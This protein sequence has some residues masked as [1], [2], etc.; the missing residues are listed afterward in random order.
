MCTRSEDRAYGV[1]LGLQERA[2]IRIEKQCHQLEVAIIWGFAIGLFE[3]CAHV[4]RRSIGC[5]S[6]CDWLV[7]STA[8]V[9]ASNGF[10]CWG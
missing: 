1:N 3:C 7:T 4:W 10:A 2:L 6:R 5:D 8:M 9:D